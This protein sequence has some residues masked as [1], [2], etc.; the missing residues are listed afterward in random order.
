[1]EADPTTYGASASADTGDQIRELEMR[2][3]LPDLNAE[4]RV[5]VV[6]EIK[7]LEAGLEDA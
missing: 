6:A 7:R 3:W 1:M 4:D 5:N 2:Y